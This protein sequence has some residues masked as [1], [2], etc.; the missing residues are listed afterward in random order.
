M[1][2][3]N[4]KLLQ[5]FKQSCIAIL[6]KVVLIFP[7]TLYFI[8]QFLG[9][10]IFAVPT[11][12][13]STYQVLLSNDAHITDDVNIS[14][15][16]IRHRHRCKHVHSTYSLTSSSTRNDMQCAIYRN[17]DAMIDF[18]GCG[19]FYLDY[20]S[21]LHAGYT[22]SLKWEQLKSTRSFFLRIHGSVN[23]SCT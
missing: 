19:T 10:E 7:C 12:N 16:L 6:C 15:Y 4:N 21:V 13:S 9:L 22:I 2:I 23:V 3:D 14:M 1:Q 8:R 18:G 5:D 20:N 17:A 11:T